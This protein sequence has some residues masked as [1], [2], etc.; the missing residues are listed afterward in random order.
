MVSQLK[1]YGQVK[2]HHLSKRG[3]NETNELD[4]FCHRT[5]E[6]CIVYAQLQTSSTSLIHL[7]R[8]SILPV[9]LK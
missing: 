3:R 6:S 9:V 2:G 1:Q 4:S 7:Q 8:I 5:M